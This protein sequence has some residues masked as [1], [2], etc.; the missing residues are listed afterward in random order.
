MVHD[1]HARLAQA[2]EGRGRL[3]MDGAMGTMLQAAGIVAGEAPET[4]L[5]RDP[6]LIEKVHRAY[7]EAGADVITTCTFGAN[8][9]KLG[10]R[11]SVAEVYGAAVACARRA[12]AP[13][14]AAD[15]GPIGQLMEPLGPMGL[16]RCEA[17]YREVARAIAATDADLIVV[18]TMTDLLEVKTAV[19]ML[20]ETGLPILCSMTFGEDGLTFLGTPPAAFAITL[21]TL[22]VAAL[23]VNCSVGPDALGPVVDELV[24]HSRVPVLC[25]P[26]AGL[27]SMEGGDTVYDLDPGEFVGQM[28]SLIEKGVTIVGGCCGTTAAHIAALRAYL[29]G[30]EAPEPRPRRWSFSAAS[31]QEVLVMEPHGA[32]RACVGER[33][34]PTGKKRLKEALRRGDM[35]YLVGEALAQREAGADLLDLNVGLPELDE[36]AVL[37]GAVQAI[38]GVCPT[39]LQLDSSDPEAL[40]RA[41]RAY[42]GKPV[43]NSVNGSAESLATVLP[44]AAEAGACVVALALDEGGVPATAEGR[45]A[46][47]ERI[48]AACGEAGIPAEDVAVD[49][50]CMAAST[51]QTAPGEVLRALRLVGEKLPVQT[52]LGVS[53]VSFGLPARPVMNAAFLSQAFGCGLSMAIMDPTAPAM[54]DA[55]AVARAV[56]GQDQGFSAY[57]DRFSSWKASEASAGAATPNL[58]A[59]ATG[60]VVAEGPEGLRELI[61]EGRRGPVAALATDLLATMEPMALVEGVLVPALDEVGRRF[62]D[63]SLFLPQLMASAEAAGEAFEVVRG[64]VAESGAQGASQAKGPVVLATVKGD[65]HDIGKNIVAMLLENYG[66]AVVDLGRDV[67]PEAV[68]QAVRDTGAP[69]VGLSALMTTTV[70]AMEET[71]ALLRREAPETFVVV[72]GAVLNPEYAQMVG[73]DAYAADAMGTVRILGGLLDG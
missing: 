70:K 4:V 27:P 23:G 67:E 48:V 61:L 21:S 25:Q 71:I 37:E 68:L 14:V 6:A 65:I 55:L 57:I 64:R 35:D 59:S 17:Y 42:G 60:A 56:S 53:N 58:A 8:G 18:E 46:I 30:L 22:G 45:L 50:L 3:L 66:Y 19:R 41:A 31:A 69:V 47:A 38:Q 2:L 40:A 24:A 36:P 51:D 9:Y 13:L 32:V 16:D 1:P 5:L 43:I 28:A 15:V 12:G 10:D 26:N 72:G 33:L 11:A 63:G 49:C 7:V 39:P 62:E 34:N 44:V 52:M 73:A 54:A 29:D 20:R